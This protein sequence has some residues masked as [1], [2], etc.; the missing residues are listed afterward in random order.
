MARATWKLVQALRQTAER[1]Q[2]GVA[3]RWSHFGQC[4]CGHLAQTVTRLSPDEIQQAAYVGAA[5]WGAQARDYCV[6]SGLPLDYIFGRL[7]ELGM[8][9]G[10]VQRLERLSDAQVLRH[11]GNVSLVHNRRDHVVLYMRAWA[12]LLEDKLLADSTVDEAPLAAE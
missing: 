11:L 9:P 10:D 12:E 2:H 8:E 5:D 6:T 4:N 7:F 3:Y 1:L